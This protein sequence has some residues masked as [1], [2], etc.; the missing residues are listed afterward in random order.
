[1]SVGALFKKLNGHLSDIAEAVK[2][3]TARKKA[4]GSGK[5]KSGNG[6]KI[7]LR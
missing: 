5:G 6:S 1:L 3:L 4:G 7:G 2:S